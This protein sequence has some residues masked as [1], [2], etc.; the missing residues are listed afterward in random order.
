MFSEKVSM[1]GQNWIYVSDILH[2]V[3]YCP[4]VGV[5]TAGP[6]AL[7]HTAWACGNTSTYGLH[8]H[9]TGTSSAYTFPQEYPDSTRHRRVKQ[10]VLSEKHR[11]T[12]FQTLEPSWVQRQN[13]D[14]IMISNIS[15]IV[16]TLW[17]WANLLVSAALCW[18]MELKNVLLS[19]KT[20]LVHWWP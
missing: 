4:Q 7:P 6:G 11:L 12:K 17:N 5:L 16:I 18:L 20:V 8:D 10:N 19:V 13:N 3:L 15:I 14:V 2:N 1:W 9:S